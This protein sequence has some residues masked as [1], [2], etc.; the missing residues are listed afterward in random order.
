MEPRISSTETREFDQSYKPP[1]KGII[2]FVPPSMV[3]LAEL[4][5]LHQPG[6]VYFLVPAL[7]GALQASVLQLTTP[8]H[9]A[10]ALLKLVITTIP[11]A[12]V[13]YSWN[14]TLDAGLDRK[15]RRT[16]H[17][18]L[19]RGAMSMRTAYL[20]NIT[21]AACCIY[22]L[23]YFPIACSAYAAPMALGA[24][25]YPFSKRFTR[26]PQM[27]FALV[28]S[29]AVLFGSAAVGTSPFIDC[30]AATESIWPCYTTQIGTNGAPI[31]WLY[32]ANVVWAV[33]YEIVYSFQDVTD[34]AQAGI[35]TITLFMGRQ[36]KVYLWML[37][38]L[39]IVLFAATGWYARNGWLYFLF[40]VVGTSA[41]LVLKLVYVDLE[42]RQSCI[43]W[44]SRGALITGGSIAAGLFG[45][46]ALKVA[47]WWKS[48]ETF[49]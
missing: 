38:L 10:W 48:A 5:R 12:F 17:R 36:P 15:V 19:A 1:T 43:W 14:D 6:F 42:D 33:F 25:V 8:P 2:Y 4:V 29:T 23:R 45:D 49:L 24:F 35:G 21:L 9:L 31:L 28:M 3:P 32:A 37:V 7:F 20:V 27:V 26:F 41:T 40:S 11:V 13:N 44:F 30:E 22:V 16:R 46:Y 39:Q 47:M 34:D 18:P